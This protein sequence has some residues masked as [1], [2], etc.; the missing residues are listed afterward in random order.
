MTISH[1][2]G[3]VHGNADALSRNALSNNETNP[4]SDLRGDNSVQQIYGLHI[5]D[6]S[7]NFFETIRKGYKE[8]IKIGKTIRILQNMNVESKEVMA[9][10][11]KPYRESLEDGKLRV[12]GDLLYAS[13]EG[14]CVIVIGDK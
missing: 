13:L 9:G 6:L 4:A 1:R 8:D 5:L 11:E 12:V 3:K 7:D 10:L 2:E 14:V